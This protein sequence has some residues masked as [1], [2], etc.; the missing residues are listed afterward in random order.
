[1][2]NI[3]Y[4]HKEKEEKYL[5]FTQGEGLAKIVDIMVLTANYKFSDNINRIQN[6]SEKLAKFKTNK[7]NIGKKI[8]KKK[9]RRDAPGLIKKSIKYKCHKEKKI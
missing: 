8:R 2:R 9:K 5:P 4:M 3:L 1:M 6:Y 7:Y